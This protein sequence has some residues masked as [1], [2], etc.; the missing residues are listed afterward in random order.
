MKY[1]MKYTNKRLNDYPVKYTNSRNMNQPFTD[2][3]MYDL[4]V[5]KGLA[6]DSLK[7]RK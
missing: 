6:G 5:F 1:K 2:I 4:D 3:K 7:S